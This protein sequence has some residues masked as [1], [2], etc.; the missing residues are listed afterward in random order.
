MDKDAAVKKALNKLDLKNDNHWTAD[1]LP[2]LESVRIYA[3]NNDLK[4]EDLTRAAPEFSRSN[5]STETKTDQPGKT[6]EQKQNDAENK[7]DTGADPDA[8]SRPDTGAPGK[9]D[10]GQTQA[11]D[12]GG[13]LK[14][15]EQPKSA[16]GPAPT[17]DQSGA[18]GHGSGDEQGTE[19]K[20]NDGQ[21]V[22]VPTEG[23]D[24]EGNV[25]GVQM[26]DL[27][28]VAGQPGGT[29]PEH[30]PQPNTMEEMHPESTGDQQAEGSDG[31]SVVIHGLPNQ[32]ITND[33]QDAD[34][35]TA[36]DGE[37]DDSADKKEIE[38]FDRQMD[39]LREKRNAAVQRKDDRTAAREKRMGQQN[40]SQSAIRSYIDAENQRRTEAG[41]VKQNL[42]RSGFNVQKTMEVLD[43][44]SPLD[45]SKANRPR[46][47]KAS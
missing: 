27:P 39:E 20:P 3:A 31:T 41:V 26:P 21:G 32:G 1:G 29:A 45:K 30:I 35:K 9:R 34:V 8:N 17:G 23:I 47:V 46:P 38:D 28:S 14:E 19:K 16:P 44:R 18:S 22:Y 42:M 6:Q 36:D 5:P 25:V 10:V 33:E 15:G 13:A 12:T 7:P 11:P 24:V 43:P 37:D 40:N 2:R 4:R